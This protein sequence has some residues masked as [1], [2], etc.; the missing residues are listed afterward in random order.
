MGDKCRQ[1]KN[2]ESVVL[3]EFTS[4][5]TITLIPTPISVWFDPGTRPKWWIMNPPSLV[6]GI[7]E[8]RSHRRIYSMLFWSWIEYPTTTS[9]LVDQL[10]FT[11]RVPDCVYELFT[12]NP[13]IIEGV[14]STP[15]NL[16]T[17]CRSRT[18]DERTIP[19]LYLISGFIED[20]VE[21]HSRVKTVV[22]RWGV[23]D[24]RPVRHSERLVW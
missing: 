3:C 16:F 8:T 11:S 24:L 23:Y 14:D 9:T 7:R 10:Q 18:V 12:T 4:P 15:R 21:W 19:V 2:D 6:Q 17:F 1:E 22:S 20:T 5:R 13:H